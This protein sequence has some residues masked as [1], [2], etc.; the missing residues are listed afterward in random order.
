MA[1]RSSNTTSLV[2]ELTF[3][4]LQETGGVSRATLVSFL[5]AARRTL[6]KSIISEETA[7]RFV[8]QLVA[9]KVL[10]TET[11]NTYVSGI[12]TREVA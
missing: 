2:D 10:E 9:D 6:D 4:F 11:Y 5:I 3:S 8:R 7:E 1:N 12:T